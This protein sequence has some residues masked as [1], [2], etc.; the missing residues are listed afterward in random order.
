MLQINPAVRS[1][2][3]PPNVMTLSTRLY[4]DSVQLSNMSPRADDIT[5]LSLVRHDSMDTGMDI[6][7]MKTKKLEVDRKYSSI[8]LALSIPYPIKT[9]EPI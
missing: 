6:A 7:A 9:R 2:Q 4:Y 1:A 5:P 3:T 8:A